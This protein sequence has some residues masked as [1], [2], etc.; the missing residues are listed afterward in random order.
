MDSSET[1]QRGTGK[2]K[3]KGSKA[4]EQESKRFRPVSAEEVTQLSSPYVPQS[5][6]RSTTWA[7]SVFETWNTNRSEK[8]PESFLEECR[9]PATMEKWLKLFVAEGM[10]NQAGEPYPPDTIYCILT[11]ILR[12]MR[13]ATPRCEVP[14]FLDRKNPDF[15]E[16]HSVTDHIYRQL[17]S[18]GIGSSKKT[19]EILSKDEETLLWTRGVLGVHTPQALLNTV[20]FSQRKESGFKRWKRAP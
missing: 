9:D 5:T 1:K 4:K 14:N 13:Q 2:R 8:C 15:R 16:L 17:R 12:F 19:T 6:N 11:G 18:A 3:G 10:Y 7:K 20:F